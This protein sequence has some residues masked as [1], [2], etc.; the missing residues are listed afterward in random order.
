MMLREGTFVG[1]ALLL[2][3][4]PADRRGICVHYSKQQT[5]L[6]INL[7]N[8]GAA[9]M[10]TRSRPAWQRGQRSKASQNIF[11]TLFHFINF[12]QP[13][14]LVNILLLIASLKHFASL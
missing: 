4:P 6:L 14:A 2:A 5:C 13:L 11:R 9:R 12:S 1:S 8:G 7:L 10:L 3:L